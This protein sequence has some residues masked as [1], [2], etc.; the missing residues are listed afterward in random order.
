MHARPVK[1]PSILAGA[2]ILALL[3]SLSLPSSP[4]LAQ[5][6][7]VLSGRVVGVDGAPLA[8]VE[9]TVEAGGAARSA[10]DGRFA[11]RTTA[12][13]LRLT[14]RAAGFESKSL[15]I[16]LPAGGQSETTIVLERLLRTSEEVVVSASRAPDSA[17]VAKSDLPRE[18][19]ERLDSAQDVPLLLTASPSITAST[20]AGNGGSG[21][22][23]IRL[24]G[25][26]QYRLN[27]TY[28]GVPLNDG[29]DMGWYFANVPGLAGA[30]DST[31]I[32][33][34]VGTSSAGAPSWGGAIAFESRDP[35]GPKDGSVEVGGGSFGSWQTV[36]ATRFGE[37]SGGLGID[38]RVVE[39]Q[40]DGFRDHSGVKQ[41]SAFL[42]V[43]WHTDSGEWRLSSF[44]GRERSELAFWAA[45]EATLR[46][47]LRFNPLASDENDRFGQD[48]V[49]LSW[50]RATEGGTALQLAGYWNRGHG[51]FLLR[52]DPADPG[53]LRSWGLDGTTLGASAL[54]SGRWEGLEWTGGFDTN[55]FDREH[56]QRIEGA[57]TNFN[58]GT[59]RQVSAFLRGSQSIGDLVV[60]GDVQWRRASFR[61][62]GS[63]DVR[64][65]DWSFVNPRLGARWNASKNGSFY[66]SVGRSEREPTRSDLFRGEDDPTEAPDLRSVRPE[67]VFDTEAGFEWTGERLALTFGLYDMEFH[68]EIALSGELSETGLPLRTNVDRSWRRG[69]EIEGTAKLGGGLLARVAANLSRNRIEKWTQHYDVYDE[70]WNWTGTAA[71]EHRDVRPI[72]TPETILSAGL[73]WA[74][75]P[76][77]T[78]GLSGRYVGKSQLDNTGDDRFTTPSFH[79][80]SLFARVDLSRWL[81]A[82]APR[83]RLDVENL[84]DEERRYAG[85]YSWLYLVENGAGERSVEGTN[86]YFPLA[87]R[88]WR[89]S[90]E[91]KF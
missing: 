41:R 10:R 45:D 33:R 17:P 69:I 5:A 32:Q 63:V 28:D 23:Y 25:I 89:L 1:M 76:E 9:V 48:L 59:K 74:I 14:A 88:S 16:D 22:G 58:T 82:M 6:T 79:D 19:I 31:Q 8:G 2:A 20:D 86:Y 27:F 56:E 42:N 52:D 75:S 36:V 35:F 49:R 26:D 81:G 54:L 7:G 60:F 40:S 83:L 15:E 43:G 53:S 34:G 13:R 29:E 62:D 77:A 68:D 24:R 90:A 72:L 38:A 80:L 47:D 55:T 37:L 87:T 51:R 57:T 67:R 70:S 18:T 39:S 71:I 91:W 30:V 78:V 3:G 46:Q 85:G 73:D 4:A 64:P 11:L 84:L 12:G 66:L 50:N 21:Y 61:Y 65:I 44:F